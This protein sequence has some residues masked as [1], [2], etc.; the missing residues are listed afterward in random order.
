MYYE[1]HLDFG[2]DAV[3]PPHRSE[4]FEDLNAYLQRIPDMLAS[5][6]MEKVIVK[7]KIRYDNTDQLQL[8]GLEANER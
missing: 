6:M 1:I 8:T 7:I 3:S 4:T 5:Q 2:D